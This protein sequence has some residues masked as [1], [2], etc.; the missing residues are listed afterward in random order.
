MALDRQIILDRA[1]EILRDDGLAALTMR[2]L[3]ADLGVA[4]GALYWHVASKQELVASVA[5][6]ILIRGPRPIS[7][8]DPST[9]AHDLRDALLSVRDG[10]D[11]VS[12][13]LALSSDRL[14]PLTRMSSAFSELP[15]ERGLWAA[16]AMTHY[17]LGA[18]AEEQ[19]RAELIRAGILTEASR[20]A[21]SDESFEFALAAIIDGLMQP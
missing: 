6:L 8:I 11:V 14:E 20:P 10:A 18:T 12:F 15:P 21:D 3:A 19:N 13:A 1:F 4:P 16:R 9:A 17:V 7:T 5:E 2:R